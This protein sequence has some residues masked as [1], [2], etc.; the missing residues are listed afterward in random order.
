LALKESI[1]QGEKIANEALIKEESIIEREKN[2]KDIESSL[3]IKQSEIA[4]EYKVLNEKQGLFDE[5]MIK[6]NKLW[7]S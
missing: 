3:K 7:E 6:I 2:I 1:K 5:K 4:E